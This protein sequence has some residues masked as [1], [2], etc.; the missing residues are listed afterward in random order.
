MEAVCKAGRE[1]RQAG[2]AATL[3]HAFA[4]RLREDGH[5]IRTAQELRGTRTSR[6]R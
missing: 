4:R 5:D 6:P 1:A 2:D 3:R